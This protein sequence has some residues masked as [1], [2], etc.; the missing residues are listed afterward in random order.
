M[1]REYTVC[2]AIGLMTVATATAGPVFEE[3]PGEDAG[4]SLTTAT[5]VSATGGGSVGVV[6]GELKGTS[7]LLGGVGDYVDLYEIYI[8]DVAQFSA[9]T[10]NLGGD[11][12]LRDPCMYLL[13]SQGLGLIAMNNQGDNNLQSRLINSD[14]Q[15][16]LLFDTPGIYYLAITSAP[17]EMLVQD[18]AGERVPLF[19]MGL[20]D[21]QQGPVYPRNAWADL[22]LYD[23]TAPTDLENYGRY[24]IMLT[25]VGSVPA[26]GVLALLGCAGLACRRRRR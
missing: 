15:G 10:M 9:E 18:A 14:G 1:I 24:E 16:G 2:V 5:S 25:G 4:Q 3:P 26:P 19:E 6:K 8:E 21:N 17:V 22:P 12:S 11:D 13:D 23:W 20:P 7:G